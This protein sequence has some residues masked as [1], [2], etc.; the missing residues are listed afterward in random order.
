M[1]K[2]IAALA[3]AAALLG[4]AASAVAHHSAVQFDFTKQVPITGKVTHF[5]AIN[6]HM[7]LT[8]LV[9]DKKGPHEIVFEGHS[10]N[11]MYRN[12]YRKGMISEGDTITVNV[13]PL[14]DGSEGGYVVSAETAKG[15]H[16]GMR[17]TRAIDAARAQAIA[18]GKAAPAP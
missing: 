3:G 17:S 11:N 18:E 13:A 5:R 7:Q 16:F 8:L 14:K 2:F 12:G 1:K 15:E 6:P 4:A 9:N 10:T